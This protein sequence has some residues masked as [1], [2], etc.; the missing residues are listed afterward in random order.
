MQFTKVVKRKNLYGQIGKILNGVSELSP[1]QMQIFSI[2]LKVDSEW[3]PILDNDTKNILNPIVRK[4]IMK[5]TKINKNNLSRY[6]AELKDKGLLVENDQGGYE[7]KSGLR[8]M[9]Q[10]NVLN[11]IFTLIIED[12]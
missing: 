10:D 2:L 7:I 3:R 11:I 6:I 9:E 4:A 1:R 5:D 12:E 8:P